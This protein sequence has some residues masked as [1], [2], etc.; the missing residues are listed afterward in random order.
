[1][2]PL[3]DVSPATRKLTYCPDGRYPLQFPAEPL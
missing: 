2:L 3:R 1:M